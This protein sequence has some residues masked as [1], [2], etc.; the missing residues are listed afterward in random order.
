MVIKRGEVGNSIS[1]EGSS[2]CVPAR[3]E[4]NL[5]SSEKQIRDRKKFFENIEDDSDD[6]GCVENDSNNGNIVF[7]PGRL[8][9]QLTILTM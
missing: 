9:I 7:A 4:V 3:N 5:L 2:S 1:F 6:D 8:Q